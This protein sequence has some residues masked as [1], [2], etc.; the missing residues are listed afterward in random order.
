M[1]GAI[2]LPD[3]GDASSL[4]SV[5]EFLRIDEPSLSRTERRVALVYALMVCFFLV[6]LLMYVYTSLTA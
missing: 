3:F 4:G 5:D 6:S 2:S 1:R